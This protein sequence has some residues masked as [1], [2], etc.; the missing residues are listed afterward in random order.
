MI[1]SKGYY[2]LTHF[3]LFLSFQ[4]QTYQQYHSV[5]QEQAAPSLSV[6]PAPGPV[7]P[8]QPPQPIQIQA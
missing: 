1:I 3:L 6:S 8:S 5:L 7:S 2:A 4:V